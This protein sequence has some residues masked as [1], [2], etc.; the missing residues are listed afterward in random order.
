MSG[1]QR[2]SIFG[3]DESD[4]SSF[5]PRPSAT[6]ATVHQKARVREISET[7]NFR[8]REPTPPAEAEASTT[9]RREPR[10]HRTGRN[11]QLNIKARQEAIDKFYRLADRTNLV[12][13]DLFERALD[14]FTRELDHQ[15]PTK[16]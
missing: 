5:Q 11:V 14:A 13:G 3:E 2:A 12:L 9:Q 4:L 8:S 16:R 15:T 10:R 6:A 1:E 7:V